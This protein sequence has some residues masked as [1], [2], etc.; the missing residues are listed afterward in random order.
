ML[1]WTRR[2]HAVDGW[3]LW[4]PDQA[5]YNKVGLANSLAVASNGF[6]FHSSIYQPHY[7]LITGKTLFGFSVF[8]T[9]LLNRPPKSP[10]VY[11]CISM[12]SIQS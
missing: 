7:Q 8:P 3:D 4:Q 9:V 11:G 2:L 12:I 5:C 1:A 6:P 10:R